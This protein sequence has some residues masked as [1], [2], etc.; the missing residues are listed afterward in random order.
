MASNETEHTEAQ[1]IFMNNVITNIQALDITYD[2]SGRRK[3]LAVL[4]ALLSKCFD[5]PIT[6]YIDDQD[7]VHIPEV[8]ITFAVGGDS[9]LATIKDF[10]RGIN[11]L[12]Y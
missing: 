8:D 4:F 9:P 1:M 10:A 2:S 7:I 3:V 6:Y 11:D 5:T 12:T